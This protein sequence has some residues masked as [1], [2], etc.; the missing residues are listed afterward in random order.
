MSLPADQLSLMAVVGYV[1]LQTVGPWGVQT[2]FDGIEWLATLATPSEDSDNKPVSVQNSNVQ[3][4]ETKV[5]VH[6]HHHYQE[7][8]LP[9]ISDGGVRQDEGGDRE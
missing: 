8:P 3:Q 6:H 7:R 1:V 5:E 9:P 4:A 2:L